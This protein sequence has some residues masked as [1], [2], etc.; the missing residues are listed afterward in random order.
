MKRV[1]IYLIL[2]LSFAVFAQQ[3]AEQSDEA[4]PVAEQ[5]PENSDNSSSDD[6][7]AGEDDESSENQT[8]DDLIAGDPDPEEEGEMDAGVEPEATEVA[9]EVEI[10]FEPDEEISEDYPVPL[11]SDI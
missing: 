7:A 9:D 4:E 10:E 5:N 8:A 3:M 2:M 1:V 11:P 6:P